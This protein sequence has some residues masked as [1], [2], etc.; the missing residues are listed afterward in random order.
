MLRTLNNASGRVI[1][2]FRLDKP[3]PVKNPFFMIYPV[4]GTLEVKEFRNNGY[5]PVHTERLTVNSFD[6]LNQLLH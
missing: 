5:R 1:K 3:Q 6:E 4:T 2:T